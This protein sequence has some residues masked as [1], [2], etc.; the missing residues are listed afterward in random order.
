MLRV[1]R[2][3]VGLI[4]REFAKTELSELVE[5]F[6]ES[7]RKDPH[8]ARV[9]EGRRES[10]DDGWGL[11]IAG[12]KNGTLTIFHEKTALP[13]F[14]EVSR[15]LLRIF[16]SK[17]S[18]YE[19]LYLLLHSRA[20]V[21]EPLGT[22]NA[23]PYEVD[24][25][26]GK[27]WFVHNGSIDKLRASQ[28]AGMDPHLHV[29]SRIAAELLAKHLS[30]CATTCEDLDQCVATAY[31]KLYNEYTREGEALITGLLSYCRGDD[32]RLYATSLVRGYENLDD[33]RRAYYSVYRVWGNG[34]NIISSS[35]LVD[36]Y[37]R[38]SN[39]SKSIQQQ[40]VLK[41]EHDSV[42]TL[43]SV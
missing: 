27:M 22:N 35:T 26:L 9:T 37:V 31:E 14:S 10:H 2:V 16:T 38:I 39:F 34:F 29:D 12:F 41:I 8:L 43:L 3:L 24:F 18:R 17:L 13:I 5:G 23:H 21:T 36:Y 40:K 25:K 7:S 28:D 20:T 6:A 1:C 32:V 42:K 15:E 33:A 4:S 19:E 30:A 11:A